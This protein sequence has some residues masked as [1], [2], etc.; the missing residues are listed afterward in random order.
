MYSTSTALTN[1]YFCR[2]VLKISYLMG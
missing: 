1:L 2:L